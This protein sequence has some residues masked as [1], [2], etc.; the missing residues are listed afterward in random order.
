[1]KMPPPTLPPVQQVLPPA[2]KSIDDE[3]ADSIPF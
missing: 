2:K 1:M 3:M